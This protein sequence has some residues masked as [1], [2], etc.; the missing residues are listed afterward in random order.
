MMKEYTIVISFPSIFRHVFVLTA[1]I[2]SLYL[3]A[4]KQSSEAEKQRDV[5]GGNKSD[6]FP[7]PQDKDKN[8]SDLVEKGGE[9]RL[10]LVN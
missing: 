7:W 5:V 9:I 6:E 1:V 3:H 8:T 4:K 10:K 2:D